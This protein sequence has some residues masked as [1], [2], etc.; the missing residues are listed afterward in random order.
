MI[1]NSA[2][3]YNNESNR[4]RYIQECEDC[5]L[6]FLHILLFSGIVTQCWQILAQS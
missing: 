6:L 5:A 2:C 1:N 3:K 4:R